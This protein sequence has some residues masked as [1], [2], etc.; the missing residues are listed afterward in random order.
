M[1]P[2]GSG[3][4]TLL[5]LLAGLDHP[6]SGTVTWPAL[7]GPRPAPRPVSVVFQGPSLL[8]ALDVIENVALPCSWPAS[9]STPPTPAPRE[10]L[11]HL[12]LGFIADKLPEE[13]SGGQMQRVAVAR[14]LAGDRSSSSPTSRPDNSTTRPA[15]SSST[16][17]STA[18]TTSVPASS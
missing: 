17:C 16:P 13:L 15:L 11:D 9:T 8:P 1:G 18:A 14:T 3:K 7:D 12:D 5:H 10:A 6:T 2:S 4:S